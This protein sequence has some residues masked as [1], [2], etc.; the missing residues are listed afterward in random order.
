MRAVL[1]DAAT[2]G[3]EDLD[4]SHLQAAVGSLRCYPLTH[5]HEIVERLA[6]AQIALVNKVILDATCLSQLPQLKHIIVLATGVNNI[7]I[8]AAKKLGISVQN[9]RAYGVDSVAQHCLMLMLTLSTKMLNYRR[10][11]NNGDWSRSGQFCM[12]DFPIES[13]A[14][15]TLGIVGYGDLGKG[16]ANLARAFGM[17]IL[18]AA[19]QGQ[20][21]A[22]GRIPLAQLLP[23]V[24][25]LSLHCPLTPATTNLIDWPELCALP[26]SALLINCARGGVVNEIALIKALDEGQISG[27]GVDV[28]TQEP[29]PINHPLLA[30]Q[31]DNL[32]ITPHTGWASRQARQ[33]ILNQATEN[34]MSV[35][36]GLSIIRGL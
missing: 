7:D 25:I 21:P 35:I 18:I 23:Q 8:E 12:L 36:S 1:L 15:K 3:P 30:V 6:G 14:G 33:A 17:T 16:V 32:I 20:H 26:N 24:D 13:L 10:A 19:R 5:A 9:C 22:N 11:I 28:L 34:V 29:P 4:F 27:A 2:L 31:R